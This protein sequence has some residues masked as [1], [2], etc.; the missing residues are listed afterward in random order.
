MAQAASQADPD[1]FSLNLNIEALLETYHGNLQDVLRAGRRTSR[2]LN[3][4]LEVLDKTN[5]SL[6]AI[7]DELKRESQDETSSKD[8]QVH[9]EKLAEKSAGSQLEQSS[10]GHDHNDIAERIH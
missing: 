6:N 10:V 5:Q 2:E 4:A 8:A 9:P 7:W 3:P 1:E